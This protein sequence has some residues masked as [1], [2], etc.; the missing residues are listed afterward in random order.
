MQGHTLFELFTSFLPAS[1]TRSPAATAIF[2]SSLRNDHAAALATRVDELRSTLKPILRS[3][4]PS[5][6]SSAET[7]DNWQAAAEQALFAAAKDL[8]QI[9]NRTLAASQSDAQDKRF[10]ANR[11]SRWTRPDAIGT[12]PRITGTKR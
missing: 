5:P 9:L 3:Q 2:L 4:S 6:R 10:R 1:R 7:N 11:G 12:V 8:D